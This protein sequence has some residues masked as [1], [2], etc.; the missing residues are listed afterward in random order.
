MIEPEQLPQPLLGVGARLDRTIRIG[1]SRCRLWTLENFVDHVALAM[2]LELERH[3][4][5]PA[6]RPGLEAIEIV[7][8]RAVWV[9]EHPFDR[10]DERALARLVGADHDRSLPVEADREVLMHADILHRD[11]KD[12]HMVSP[13]FANSWSRAIA[14]PASAASSPPPSIWLCS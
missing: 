1:Q 10:I 14:V 9:A 7:G 11:R 4:G 12:S 8:G 3:L 2:P 5:R 13:A 6:A